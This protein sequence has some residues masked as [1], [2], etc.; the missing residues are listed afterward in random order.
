VS[1]VGDRTPVHV[2]LLSPEFMADPYPT[3]RRLRE[4]SPVYRSDQGFWIVTRYH[5]VVPLLDDPRF[6]RAI[7]LWKPFEPVVAA[8]GETPLKRDFFSALSQLDPPEHTELRRV[9]Q[10][11]FTAATAERSRRDVQ[12]LAD[13]AVDRLLDERGG[14]LHALLS[15]QVPIRVLARL[16]GVPRSEEDRFASLANRLRDATRM[17][18]TPLERSVGLAAVG[19]MEG[20]INDILRAAGDGLLATLAGALDGDTVNSLV[21]TLIIAGAEPPAYLVDLGV[22][23]LFTHRDQLRLVQESPVLL[24]DAVLEILRFNHIGRFVQRL[25]REDVR[26]GGTEIRAGEMVFAGIAAAHRDPEVFPDPDRF[27][28]R[29][30]TTAAI[31]FGRGRFTCLAQHLARLE[32]EVILS[33]VIRR[34]PE[35]HF[36]AEGIGWDTSLYLRSMARF[37]VSV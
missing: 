18:A 4:E 16:F 3:Y 26:V 29:R 33:T 25:P 20:L 24:G 7:R 5:D 31:P 10:Q 13:Q 8:M 12:E 36:G 23:T 2:D 14:D 32:G 27:D 34:L 9:V 1:V 15:M 22:M 35:L 17:T 19:E 28:V 30:R 21:R 11:G 37:E 6:T